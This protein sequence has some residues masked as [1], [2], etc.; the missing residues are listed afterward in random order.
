MLKIRGDYSDRSLRRKEILRGSCS[1]HTVRAGNQVFII[2]GHC[3]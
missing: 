2:L 3:P 1:R